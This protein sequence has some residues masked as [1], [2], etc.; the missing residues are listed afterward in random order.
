MSI[1]ISHNKKKKEVSFELNREIR[2]HGKDRVRDKQKATIYTDLHLL[3][4]SGLDINTTLEIILQQ[5]LNEKIRSK[6]AD[7]HRQVIAGVSLADSMH[8]AGLADEYEYHSLRIG[9]EN[10][11]ITEV[12]GEIKKYFSRRVKQRRLVTSAL[13]YPVMVLV[14]ALVAVGFMLNVIVPM[15]EEVFKRFQGELPALTQRIIDA[16]EWTKQYFWILI[17]LMAGISFAL[18]R[19]WKNEKFRKAVQRVLLQVPVFGKLTK[20]LQT[21]RFCHI[22]ELLSSARSPLIQSLH[23]LEDMTT[24]MPLKKSISEMAANISGGD[25]F[26]GSAE[27]TGFFDRKFCSLIKAGEEVNQLEKAFHQLNEQYNQ[28]SEHRLGV[29]SSMLEP[30]LIILV[31]GLVAVIL[32][33]MY[34][35]LFKI[36]TSLY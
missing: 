12:L 22:M 16:S 7:V 28:E 2:L 4:S 19:L 34:L 1:S 21:A 35:P 26:H 20:D 24:F 27:G 13:T 14:T 18:V 33:A 6:F 25:S 11:K 5:S 17:L 15:F 31:G 9:E 30:M 36:G 8:D 10:G 3:L 23:M 32:V 29:L